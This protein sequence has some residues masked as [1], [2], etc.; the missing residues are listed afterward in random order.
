MA[1]MESQKERFEAPFLPHLR[2]F[3]KPILRSVAATCAAG[4]A[5][6]TVQPL[7]VERQSNSIVPQG[8]DQRTAASAEHKDVSGE[9]ITTKAFL[10]Q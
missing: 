9:R 1:V 6:P 8:L 5:S 2:T 7:G 3:S 4:C 10:H